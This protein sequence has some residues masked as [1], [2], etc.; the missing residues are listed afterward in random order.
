MKGGLLG[1][2]SLVVVGGIIGD[3]LAHPKGTAAGLNG[4]NNVLKTSFSTALGGKK[5]S[6]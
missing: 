6:G 5:V 3:I 2:V 1:I 4:L